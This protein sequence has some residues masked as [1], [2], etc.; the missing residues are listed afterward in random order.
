MASTNSSESSV[1][2]FFSTNDPTLPL[3]AECSQINVPSDIGRYG[4]SRILNSSPMLNT[5][6]PVPLDFLINGDFLRGSLSEYLSANGLSPETTVEVVYVRALVPPK[7][8]KSFEHPD[9]VS[10]VDVLSATSPAAAWWPGKFSGGQEGDER[11]LSS[12]FDS[13]LRIWTPQGECIAATPA[14]DEGGHRM[15][16]KSAKFLSPSRIA[17]A[18]MD[19]TVRIWKYSEDNTS[20]IVAGSLKPA[21]VLKGHMHP[22]T[23][24]DVRGNK[25]RL[26][27]ADSGGSIGIWTSSKESA[28]AAP[29]EVSSS[30]SIAKR[31]KI[32]TTAVNTAIRGPLSLNSHH[33][34]SA[35]ACFDSSD[36]S[37]GYS[38]GF[39]DHLIRTLDLTTS[40]SVS[41]IPLT[42]PVTSL[43]S[44]SGSMAPVVAA[45]TA[46]RRVILVDPREGGSS[47]TSVLTL[48]G[49]SNWVSGLAQCPPSSSASSEG[50]SGNGGSDYTLASASYDGSI[51]VWDLRAGG[52]QNAASN[53]DAGPVAKPVYVIDREAYRGKKRPLAGEGIKVFGLTWDEKCGIVSGGEDMKVQV[54]RWEV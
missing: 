13:L 46:S 45:G 1:R 51:M 14:P 53:E 7:F 48:K 44:L 32:T 35:V 30:S 11:V 15:P 2:I 4:L 26:L 31:R 52:A 8:D 6:S 18:G 25:S 17:S 10:S 23:T 40:T 9:W 42:A 36:A 20:G 5:T 3:P 16:V 39:N 50:S 33:S 47:R 34:G 28:P 12:S 29:E 41:S 27:T 43:F 49:H 37:V 22:L 21:L 54:D 19:R 24:L 38:G